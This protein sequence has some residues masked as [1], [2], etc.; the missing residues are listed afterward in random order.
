VDARL[1]D[2]RGGPLHGLGG[3]GS[4][5]RGAD[6]AHAGCAG[7][8][9]CTVTRWMRG[10]ARCAGRPRRPAG[11]LFTSSGRQRASGALRSRWRLRRSSWR[12]RRPCNTPPSAACA[13]GRLSS[14]SGKFGRVVEQHAAALGSTRRQAPDRRRRSRKSELGFRRRRHRRRRHRRGAWASGNGTRGVVGEGG[15]P[16]GEGAG[17]GTPIGAG[18]P[19]VARGVCAARDAAAGHPP[20]RRAS[21]RCSPAQTERHRHRQ[22]LEGCRSALLTP[23]MSAHAT[24]VRT[25]RAAVQSRAVRARVAHWARLDGR[26][27][28]VTTAAGNRECDGHRHLSV[29]WACR[30]NRCPR[31]GTTTM[32]CAA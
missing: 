16:P 21:P 20:R 17:A 13:C 5:W 12:P 32:R 19:V 10:T 29:Y 18:T 7:N 22:I 3:A 25:I 9:G 24:R 31:G 8:A 2:D 27:R 30:L 11:G 4:G 23:K 6:V 1:G 26:W 28:R 14:R 15:A